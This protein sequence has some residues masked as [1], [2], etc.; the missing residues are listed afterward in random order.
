MTEDAMMTWV[1]HYKT[2]IDK[3][4]C[5]P[6]TVLSANILIRAWYAYL[7]GIHLIRGHQVLEQFLRQVVDPSTD[8]PPPSTVVHNY[9]SSMGSNTVAQGENIPVIPHKH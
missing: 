2:T 9:S 8:A 6:G 3:V 1:N 7:G 5:L 4:R